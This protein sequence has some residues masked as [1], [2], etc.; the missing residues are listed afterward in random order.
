[1]ILRPPRATRTDTLFPYTTLFRSIPVALVLGPL[2][3]GAGLAGT[4]LVDFDVFLCLAI[5]LVLTVA[6]SFGLKARPV[7]DVLT[8]GALLTLRRLRSEERRV[9][10]E[11]VST[12]GYRWS[13][14]S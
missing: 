3:I 8:L 9:G 1:M 5:Y 10:K 11:W 13:P 14:C 2:L 12:C 4:L 7:V 6:Y